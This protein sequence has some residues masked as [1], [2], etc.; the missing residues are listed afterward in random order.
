M[1]QGVITVHQARGVSGPV[2][3]ETL[4]QPSERGVSVKVSATG[5]PTAHVVWGARVTHFPFR[6][7]VFLNPTTVIASLNHL[8]V[9][10]VMHIVGWENESHCVVAKGKSGWTLCISH[11][12][13]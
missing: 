5:K 11:Q 10:I 3:Q 13:K 7:Q 4:Q 1:V 2:S 9:H 6:R 8:P 12:M